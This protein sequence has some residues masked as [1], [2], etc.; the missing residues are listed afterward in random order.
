MWVDASMGRLMFDKR[1]RRLW[2][3]AN[4]VGFGAGGAV[5]GALQ[6][7]QTQPYFGTVTSAVEAARVEARTTAVSLIVFGLL[8]GTAQWLVL[9]RVLRASAW[10]IAATML[11]WILLGVTA[12]IV[13]G[14]IGGK[15]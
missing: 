11:G 8:V 7:L 9:R 3:I 10:W 1:V 6:R 14:F 12:G 2:L 5:V 4:V 13:S 15:I